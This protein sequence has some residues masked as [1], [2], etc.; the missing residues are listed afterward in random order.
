MNS[1]CYRDLV[2][3]EMVVLHAHEPIVAAIPAWT[4][5]YPCDWTCHRWLQHIHSCCMVCI[6]FDQ[7]QAAGQRNNNSSRF[8][9]AADA[10]SARHIG[11]VAHAPPA[12]TTGARDT[13]YP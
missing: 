6:S 10:Y 5:Q 1:T 13:Y 3:Q 2:V 4:K 8:N 11:A 7:T 9:A 12:A